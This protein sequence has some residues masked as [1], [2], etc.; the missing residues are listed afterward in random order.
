M[1]AG[2]ADG[3]V[4][5][6]EAR[7]QL[8]LD[9]ASLGAS[10]A[11]VSV[12]R[13]RVAR[14]EVGTPLLIHSGLPAVEIV[15]SVLPEGVTMVADTKICDAGKRIAGDAF[16]A[17][18]D[19][20]T[21]AGAAVDEPTWRGVLEAALALPTVPGTVMVDTVG[22]PAPAAA[23]GLRGLVRMA[24][25]AGVVV[26]DPCPPAQAP[27]AAIFGIVRGVPDRGAPMDVR[28][29]V[30]GQVVGGLVEPAL[31][32]GFAVV[33]VGGVVSDADD[34]SAV[35]ARLLRRGGHGGGG[36]TVGAMTVAP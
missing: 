29:L 12:L 8:A 15:R 35:W 36:M 30:A 19:V 1:T 21:V 6:P 11:L 34:P 5:R 9:V 23:P 17:G 3:G 16:A 13:S 14:V 18:A 31:K 2:N 33:I 26:E 28:Y 20:V 4:G 10:L 32:A 27:A 25:D 7:L 22:W 24:Q